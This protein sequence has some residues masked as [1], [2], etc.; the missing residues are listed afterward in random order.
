M[1]NSRLYTI[2]WKT[3]FS[4]APQP[5]QFRGFFLGTVFLTLSAE[6]CSPPRRFPCPQTRFQG[7]GRGSS[8]SRKGGSRAGHLTEHSSPSG[9]RALW[10]VLPP[11]IPQLCLPRRARPHPHPQNPLPALQC[12]PLVPACLSVCAKRFGLGPV[13]FISL[14]C[15]LG[16]WML[17]LDPPSPSALQLPANPLLRATPRSASGSGEEAGHEGADGKRGK[18]AGR[19]L[20]APCSQGTPRA[21]RQ[22]GR[23]LAHVAGRAG[24][25]A[26]VFRPGR[27]A[28]RPWQVEI[29][30]CPGTLEIS[31]Q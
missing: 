14:L 11:G 8:L 31:T 29:C 3:L 22:P 27:A 10:T 24:D 12:R 30:T 13:L 2:S 20:P 28:E 17:S 26:L 21:G 16:P 4:R 18:Q 9:G 5:L 25:R 1:I 7:G 23:R 15:L 19:R 6:G